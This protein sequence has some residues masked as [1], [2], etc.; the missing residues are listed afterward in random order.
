[1]PFAQFRADMTRAMN[2]RRLYARINALPD[3]TV[4]E[5]P[6]AGD[7]TG[8]TGSFVSLRRKPFIANPFERDAVLVT[9]VE[10]HHPMQG[11]APWRQTLG[12]GNWPTRQ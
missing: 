10:A 12:V 2:R 9:P 4:R 1:M 7:P 8:V 11:R 6:R 5:E 3:S